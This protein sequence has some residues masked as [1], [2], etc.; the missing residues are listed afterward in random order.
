MPVYD[1]PIVDAHHHFWRPAH[2]HIPWLRPGA[3]IPFRYGDYDSIKRAYLPPDYLADARGF[4]IVGTV[5]METEWEL[6]DPIGEIRDLED[7]RDAFGLPDAAVAH[8]VLADPDVEHVLETF[9]G[10]HPIVRA[11][12][13]K[14][15][16]A[17]TAAQA[18]SCR[19]LMMDPRWRAGYAL[20]HRHG[21]HFELQ[22]AWWHLHEALDLVR[23]FP[24]T[25][26]TINHAALPADRSPEGLAGWTAAL[27]EV[28]AAEQVSIKIS[29]IGLP[30]QAWTVANNR[31]IVETIAEIFGA[32]RIMFASNFPVDG[33]TGSF[34]DI[35]GG[36]LEIS[37]DWSRAEQ[38]AAFI[39]NAVR[40]Y[41]L[42]PLISRRGVGSL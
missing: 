40:V 42:D 36:F 34:R 33:L 25:P 6:D 29:G 16:Q 1:G 24:Q 35:Y 22:T 23:A 26:I 7:I 9:A 27:R 31:V 14:P 10:E 8:A 28:A 39:D 17:P 5:T 3:R 30:G 11:I 12:R 18:R 37:R 41:R 20:L 19:T 38:A 13:E 15:G 32:G 4:N 21:L 2:G